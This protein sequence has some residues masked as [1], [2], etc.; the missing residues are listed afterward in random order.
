MVRPLR[1]EYP[2]A[3]YH[4][5][6]R[7]RRGEQ[8]FLEEKD[9]ET[10]LELLIESAQL[11]NLRIAAYCQMP[12]HYHLLIQTP[13]ANLSRCMRHI[14]GVYTQRFNRLHHCDGQLFR[15]RYKAILVEADSY[16][17]QLVRYI[18]RN[19]LRAGMVEV[20]DAYEWSSHRGYLSKAKKW[21]WLDKDFVL[22]LLS[23]HKNQQRRR[24]REFIAQED[25]AEISRVFE[26]KKLPPLL[27]SKGF[28]DHIRNQ[29]SDSKQHIEVPESKMLA[30]DREEIKALV[31][32]IYGVSEEDLFKSKRGVFNEPRSVA[33]YLTRQLRGE[34]L[35]EICRDYGLKTHSSA[36]SAVEKVRCEMNK[37]RR[38]K[39][40]V[41]KVARMLVILHSEI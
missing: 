13:E 26:K 28:I 30:P 18:H 4:V 22:S 32:Q 33:I 9:Y 38:F 10:F 15:G 41:D 3:W 25:S 34:N 7:G 14:N 11:W 37:D 1:I 8:I 16:L 17:L 23:E 24:Y 6:N 40:G 20:L 2:D 12:N 39:K 36:S 19:P 21:N 27:G 35:A 29:F 31:S 5:M